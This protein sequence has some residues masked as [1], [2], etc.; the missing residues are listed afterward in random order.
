MGV[1][2]NLDT[3]QK[4]GVSPV[5]DGITAVSDGITAVSGGI[6]AVSGGGITR[7]PHLSEPG[8]VIR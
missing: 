7:L 8:T 3:L 5:L 1:K 2:C 6:T 4:R